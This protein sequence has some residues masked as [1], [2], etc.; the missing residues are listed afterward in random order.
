LF[1]RGAPRNG[2]RLNA[3]RRQRI[4]DVTRRFDEYRLQPARPCAFHILGEVVEEHWPHSSRSSRF[5]DQ[6]AR[7]NM[8][9]ITRKTS[10]FDLPQ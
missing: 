4:R 5:L 2:G 6:A 10:E 8:A 7:P 3:Q 1:L 9:A